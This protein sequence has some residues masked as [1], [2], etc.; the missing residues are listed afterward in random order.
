MMKMSLAALIAIPVVV[1][2]AVRAHVERAPAMLRYTV[3]PDGNE[4]RRQP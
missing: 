1:N 4:A 2:P 3:A